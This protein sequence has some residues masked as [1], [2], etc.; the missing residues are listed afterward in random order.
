MTMIPMFDPIQTFGRGLE[1][2]DGEILPV[3]MAYNV[4][5]ELRRSLDEYGKALPPEQ[6][7]NDD[8]DTIRQSFD[9]IEAMYPAPEELDEYIDTFERKQHVSTEDVIAIETKWPGLI[10]NSGIALE[11]Y[12]PYPSK[13]NLQ[14]TVESL[15]LA[16]DVALAIA[17]LGAIIKLVMW[18]GSFN[19]PKDF[20]DEIEELLKGDTSS[21]K[22]LQSW[23]KA[24]SAEERE[25]ILDAIRGGKGDTLPGFG[26]ASIEDISKVLNAEWDVAKLLMTA[27]EGDLHKLGAV[28]ILRD[29]EQYFKIMKGLNS[30]MDAHGKE[31]I[32]FINSYAAW[33]SNPNTV[34]LLAAENSTSTDP[35]DLSVKLGQTPKAPKDFFD[36]VS[37]NLGIQAMTVEIS[38]AHVTTFQEEPYKE[39]INNISLPGK[40]ENK[41]NADAIKIFDDNK[42]VLDACITYYNLGAKLGGSIDVKKIKESLQ[43]TL[44]SYQDV[45]K[46]YGAKIGDAAKAAS[47]AVRE[48]DKSKDGEAPKPE[49]GGNTTG[50]QPA[51]NSYY[52]DLRRAL[53]MAA[54]QRDNDQDN[55]ANKPTQGNDSK[56]ETPK[57]PSAFTDFTNKLSTS[58]SQT[59]DLLTK[60]LWL[61]EAILIMY[62]K[63][64]KLA[65][66][67][68]AAQF[69][70]KEVDDKD[71]K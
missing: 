19:K 15:A 40:V 52:G 1:S 41:P 46:H 44:K 37:T 30:A 3:K 49:Q 6:T 45:A 71:K 27:R 66:A 64:G 26:N 38:G 63:L 31:I 24:T 21:E 9:D 50:T 60:T 62:S 57:P 23:V 10:V 69:K 32:E 28:P 18:V 39:I 51:T 42:A 22:F 68:T 54:D 20:S 56:P 5:E 12:T 2:T 8:L 16:K 11:Q 13:V 61:T 48:G 35:T 65:D 58:C 55:I 34:K 53:E 70:I 17:A 14:A 33:S 36:K 67:T 43:K 7:G 59:K 25:A 29:K 4:E 47:N